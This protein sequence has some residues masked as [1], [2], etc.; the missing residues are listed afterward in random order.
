MTMVQ[1]P[2]KFHL[3]KKYFQAFCT[4]CV[5]ANHLAEIYDPYFDIRVTTEKFVQNSGSLSNF[6]EIFSFFRVFVGEPVDVEVET[7]FD[8]STGL[9]YFLARNVHLE[10]FKI[11]FV[12]GFARFSFI[13]DGRFT[14][15]TLITCIGIDRDGRKYETDTLVTLEQLPNDVSFGGLFRKFKL[16]FSFR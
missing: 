16:N 11:L 3:F 4:A 6:N 13:P 2:T 8:I 7:I 5:T 14:P 12:D 15:V 1:P 9:C 10:L